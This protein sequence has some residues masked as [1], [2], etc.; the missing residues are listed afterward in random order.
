M[1][2]H[3]LFVSYNYSFQK[4]AVENIVKPDFGTNLGLVNCGILFNRRLVIWG[5]RNL[6]VDELLIGRQINRFFR[7]RGLFYKCWFLT[8]LINR[9]LY[10]TQNLF[11]KT[12]QSIQ[13]T[14]PSRGREIWP[15]ANIHIIFLSVSSVEETP[16]FRG[17]G[18]FLNPRF[19]LHSGDTLVLRT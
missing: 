18:H 6:I 1:C 7:D 2:C 14:I 15:R 3:Q 12:P 11:I 13:G 9:I 10:S 8:G 5:I 16:L 4:Q 19:F 17:K